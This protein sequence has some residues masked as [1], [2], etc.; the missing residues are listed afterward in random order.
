MHHLKD[1][2]ASK[3]FISLLRP[4]TRFLEY[5]PAETVLH[6]NQTLQER[7]EHQASEIYT[8]VA[9]SKQIALTSLTMEMRC[10]QPGLY[11][12]VPTEVRPNLTQTSLQLVDF[13]RPSN[14]GS[15]DL[16]KAVASLSLSATAVNTIEKSVRA[17]VDTS[18]VAASSVLPGLA[19]GV[20]G[21]AAGIAALNTFKTF[22]QVEI[23]RRA[24]DASERSAIMAE[25]VG[26][27]NLE[28]IRLQTRKTRM[29]I[30]EAR[31]KQVSDAA[32][33][34]S[35]GTDD[36]DDFDGT[37]N[38]GHNEKLSSPS[39]RDRP[40]QKSSGQ[41]KSLTV[42]SKSDKNAMSIKDTPKEGQASR[43]SLQTKPNSNMPGNNGSSRKD[44]PQVDADHV[45]GDSPSLQSQGEKN[46]AERSM[47]MIKELTTL[48]TP[49]DELKPKESGGR[50]EFDRK[51]SV[52]PNE[53]RH[54]ERLRTE[55]ALNS[56]LESTRAQYQE[57]Y[58]KPAFTSGI[59][60][61]T[62]SVYDAEAAI[63]LVASAHTS[64][65]STAK[66]DTV[67]SIASGNVHS[68]LYESASEGGDASGPGSGPDTRQGEVESGSSEHFSQALEKEFPQDKDRFC[69]H[70][71]SRA[72]GVE[73]EEVDDGVGCV[74]HTS[75]DIELI[76][77]NS[78]AFVRD[79]DEG[80]KNR[81]QKSNDV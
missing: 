53:K 42:V 2:E 11:S 3:K 64:F 78:R 14:I 43:S 58:S 45:L 79:G 56:K 61:D 48:H 73:P 55:A 28:L 7:L 59:N 27:E 23:A 36:D 24:A 22:Q 10:L 66:G 41:R 5:A 50:A 30:K 40:G 21:T 18:T 39:A 75:T 74:G 31:K 25:S 67:E 77:R 38:D 46:E 13:S 16:P 54:N 80:D 34:D 76:A 20:A 29:D 69:F 35:H 6:P 37:G 12:S 9:A 65:E 60:V 44:R 47:R 26:K 72:S 68:E 1:A 70:S 57:D 63:P 17:T 62:K 15:S 81:E 71:P 8:P 19:V 33:E 51:I 52:G 49:R 4:R 32:M